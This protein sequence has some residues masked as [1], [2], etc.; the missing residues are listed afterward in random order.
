MTFA[1]PSASFRIEMI[2][3][4]VNRLFRLGSAGLVQ[5]RDPFSGRPE[6]LGLPQEG[7]EVAE[8]L[9]RL[10]LDPAYCRGSQVPDQNRN[11]ER[12]S[13]RKDVSER[14]RPDLAERGALFGVAP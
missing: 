14:G 7:P 10:D 6:I 3:D 2:W 5:H 9:L 1:P 11:D 8:H 4:S 13:N 12:A